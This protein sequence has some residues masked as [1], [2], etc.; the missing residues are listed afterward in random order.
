MHGATLKIKNLFS[1]IDVYRI[2]G[3]KSSKQKNYL[4]GLS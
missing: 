1:G 2:L 3:G 4:E